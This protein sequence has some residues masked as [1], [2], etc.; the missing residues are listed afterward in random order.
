MYYISTDAHS[1]DGFEGRVSKTQFTPRKG[2]GE[3]EE[4]GVPV[5]GQ[6]TNISS[7]KA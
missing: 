7:K 5:E 1:K 4:W 3:H 6:P 2:G